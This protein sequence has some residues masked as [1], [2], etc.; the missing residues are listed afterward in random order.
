MKSDQVARILHWLGT[1]SS[2]EQLPSASTC[3]AKLKLPAYNSLDT[4]RNKLFQ[5][6]DLYEGFAEAAVADA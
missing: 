5:A 6:I 3:F 1:D 2:E 4:M